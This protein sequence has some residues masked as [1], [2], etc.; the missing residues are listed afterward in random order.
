MLC[1]VAL[2]ALIGLLVAS[3]RGGIT[4]AYRDVS[5][6]DLGVRLAI[7]IDPWHRRARLVGERGF[8]GSRF[9]PLPPGMHAADLGRAQ[10]LVAF[11]ATPDGELIRAALGRRPRWAAFVKRKKKNDART[12][13]DPSKTAA[14][15]LLLQEREFRH[16]NGLISPWKEGCRAVSKGGCRG[17]TACLG[18]V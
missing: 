10:R 9:R 6:A 13:C 11:S 7:A 16:I 4:A 2:S 17:K 12:G 8:G 15:R 14:Y 1:A 3:R 5:L 18:S